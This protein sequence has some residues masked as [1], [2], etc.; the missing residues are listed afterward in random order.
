MSLY[1]TYTVW[2]FLFSFFLFF[3]YNFILVLFS[4]L[5]FPLLS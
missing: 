5:L 4:Y 1:R 2:N 3:N